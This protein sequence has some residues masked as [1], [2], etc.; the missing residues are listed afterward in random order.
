MRSLWTTI[1]KQLKRRVPPRAVLLV[2]G[3]F[4]FSQVVNIPEGMSSAEVDQFTE[5]SLESLAPFPLEQLA[6]GFIHDPDSGRILLYAAHL[7]RLR[8]AGFE[9][10]DSSYHVFPSFAAARNRKPSR[11]SVSFVR[12]LNSLSIV[13]F[14]PKNP[15]PSKVTS[16]PLE[17]EEFDTEGKAASGDC[18]VLLDREGML[19][20]KK[21]AEEGIWSVDECR[22]E[23]DDSIKIASRFDP[24]R[25][26]RETSEESRNLALDEEGIWRADVRTKSLLQKL[27]KERSL[28]L[29]LWKATVTAGIAAA[30]L[31]FLQIGFWAAGFWISRMESTVIANAE[32]V[33]AIDQRDKFANTIEQRIQKE[34]RPFA[35]LEAM[36][37]ERPKTV[38]F[39]E[40]DSDAINQNQMIVKGLGSNVEAVN[41]YSRLLTQSPR[42]IEVI[43]DVASR[44]GKAPFTLTV[45]FDSALLTPSEVVAEAKTIDIDESQSN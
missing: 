28:S 26:S 42:I 35:M 30:F 1:E 22:V 9:N 33:L 16:F 15:I 43:N 45:T 32:E 4:F 3:E 6:W 7:E 36:N 37:V 2:P 24:F 41:R 25:K 18:H 38:H 23:D 8:S 14:D 39:T 17:E 20:S 10:L 19:D 13:S 21:D 12:Y 29:T 34:F 11:A 31:L 40:A 5:F 44:R 27:R